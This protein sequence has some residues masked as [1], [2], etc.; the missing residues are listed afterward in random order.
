MGLLMNCDLAHNYTMAK[1][2]VGY[3]EQLAKMS[4][5]MRH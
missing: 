5:V 4:R 2:L 1:G 3:L